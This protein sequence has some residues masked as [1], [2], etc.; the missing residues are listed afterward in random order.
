MDV[1]EWDNY[2]MTDGE[3]VVAHDGTTNRTVRDDQGNPVS[4]TWESLKTSDLTNLDAS[5]RDPAF[6]TYY[7]SD[8]IDDLPPTLRQ[9]FGQFQGT[10]LFFPEA[11]GSSP[12]K[13]R[14]VGQKIADV[15]AAYGVAEAT[16]IY[17]AT[18]MHTI[19]AKGCKLVRWDIGQNGNKP[20]T[21]AWL[22]ETRALG[23]FGILIDWRYLP[24]STQDACAARGLRTFAF[25]YVRPDQ[26]TVMPDVA[27]AFDPFV[28]RGDSLTLRRDTFQRTYPGPGYVRPSTGSAPISYP[29][30]R[31]LTLTD[32]TRRKALGWPR[33]HTSATGISR[34]GITGL[35]PSAVSYTIDFD[36]IFTELGSDLS[37]SAMFY[38]ELDTA[39][40]LEEGGASSDSS[41][42]YA[43]MVRSNGTI[44]LYRYAGTPPAATQLGTIS[45][46]ALLGPPAL[47]T[48]IPCRI[49]VTASGVTGIVGYGTAS[50]TQ[51]YAAD[52]TYRG[53]RYMQFE[54]RGH[55]VM[56]ANLRVS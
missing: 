13:H 16:C 49:S 17:S 10:T 18:D 35:R 24:Q 1:I 23:Y 12:A 52:T 46:I 36:L 42:G 4:A 32:G 21:L 37:R 6:A 20:P 5:Y 56:L 2:L 14:Q 28:V 53:R 25:T 34:I 51:V 22:D 9:V 31:E 7:D 41:T 8:F 39:G 50:P 44:N 33:K 30:I 48:V 47:N 55:G 11:K 43:F 19:N 15:A 27:I 3:V 45:G 29:V 54:R 40:P 26:L 38:F